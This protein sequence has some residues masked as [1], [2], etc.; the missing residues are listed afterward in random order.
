VS[1]DVNKPGYVLVFS[2]VV[3]A[4]FTGAIMT[5]HALS[6]D[7]AARNARLF[8][9]K[10]VVEV[11]GLG[12]AAEMSDDEILDTYERRITPLDVPLRDPETGTVFNDPNAAGGAK[13]LVARGP[14]GEVLGYALP[15]WGVG[16]WARIDGYLALTPGLD[17]IVGVV[18]L[19]HSETPGLG[20]RLTEPR[21]RAGFK[22]LNVQPPRA[23]EKYLYVGGE[24]PAS[25]DHPKH[26]RHVDAITGATGTSSAVERFLN[27]RLAEFHRA[28]AAAGL[29]GAKSDA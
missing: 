26:G 16:F 5:L 18:F 24:A 22:G 21:W 12:T 17:R 14:G 27:D 23:G 10:G 3:S 29:T 11:F 8:E 2:A 4:A 15:V 28:A 1:R 7:A 20:G 25:P 13:T 9:R 19:R 6:A